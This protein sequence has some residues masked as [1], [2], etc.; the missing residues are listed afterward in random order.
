M[1][2]PACIVLD[3]SSS[4]RHR[5][6]RDAWL[7]LVLPD[8]AAFLQFLSTF[9]LHVQKLDPSASTQLK[10]TTVLLHTYAIQSVNARLQMPRIGA[11]AGL[12]AAVISFIAHYVCVYR[13][14]QTA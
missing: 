1:L 5:G 12:L 3:N 11:D 9:A 4:N 6:Y 7:P 14:G 13:P 8:P 10:R 2:K